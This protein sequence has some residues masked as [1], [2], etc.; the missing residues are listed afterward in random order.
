MNAETKLLARV[1]SQKPGQLQWGRV[2]MNAET[3]I[4]MT[5]EQFATILNAFSESVQEV[6]RS[7]LVP[8]AMEYLKDAP[9]DITDKCNPKSIELFCR[10]MIAKKLLPPGWEIVNEKQVVRVSVAEL[11]TD[12]T[13]PSM[14]N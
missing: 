4:P 10:W 9:K 14:M 11:V 5:D 13:P 12:P 3:R 2:L 6:L 7:K 8:D 1:G